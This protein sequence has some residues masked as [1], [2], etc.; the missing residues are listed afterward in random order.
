MMRETAIFLFVVL[1]T[2]FPPPNNG[3]PVTE[4]DDYDNGDVPADY[5][6]YS[7]DYESG[8]PPPPPNL[9][10]LTASLGYTGK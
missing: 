7:Y 8:G 3:L 2:F 9:C 5:S 1:V 6:D 4:N 10:Q